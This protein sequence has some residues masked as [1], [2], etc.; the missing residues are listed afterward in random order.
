MTR[1]IS[2]ISGKGGVGKTTLVSNL[3]ASLAKKGKNV[4]VIDGNVTGANLGMHLGLP[5]A[6][7]YPISLNE[8]LRNDAFIT[9]AM[10]RHP[11]GF[12]V[13]PAHLDDLSIDY[14]GLKKC[15]KP[16]IGANDF[17]LIDAA[18]GTDKEV[19]A[20]IE[21]SDAVLIV[22]NPEHPAVAN[23]VAARKLAERKG[24]EVLG[25]V[26]NK[27]MREGHELTEESIESMTE[28]PVL[29][30][31]HDH[32]KVREAIAHRKPLVLHAPKN[33]TSK[34]I[35]QLAGHLCGE[36]PQKQGLAALHEQIMEFLRRDF[37]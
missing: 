30:T 36:E 26:L 10:Y 29:A 28:M 4:T 32:R 20:A 31:L 23:A 17:I 16:L 33:R 37:P 19:E 2:V 22:T 5:S 9:Q 14:G 21:T 8:V 3:G 25:L 7:C 11:A 27:V 18:A 15:I 13:I 12:S 35:V 34:A 24:K 6:D 1:I